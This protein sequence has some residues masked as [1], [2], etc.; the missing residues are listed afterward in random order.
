MKV[1][2]FLKGCI[3]RHRYLKKKQASSLIQRYLKSFIAR[4]AVQA[5]LKANR[6]KAQLAGLALQLKRASKLELIK[7][8]NASDV[9]QQKLYHDKIARRKQARVLRAEMAKLP[10]ICRASYIK[11]QLLKDDSRRLNEDK[12]SILL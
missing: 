11:M 7:L 8:H 4:R 5:E 10:Y 1:K 12:D 9:I 6:E 2:W 3:C